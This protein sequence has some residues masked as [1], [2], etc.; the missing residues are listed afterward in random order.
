MLKLILFDYD[1]LM[2]NSEQVVYKAL[3]D[4]FGKYHHDLT[5]EYYTRHI[6]TPVQDALT[7]FFADYPLPISYDEFFALRNTMVAEYLA[8][9]LHLMPGLLSLLEFLS[10][11]AIPLAITT[12]G[13]RDYIQKGLERFRIGQ[14]FQTIVC[15]DDVKRGK[16]YPDLILE[17]LHRASCKASDAILL[18]DSP[19]GIE[20][21]QRAQIASIAIPTTGVD[22]NK[23][24]DASAIC[25]NLSEVEHW[26][27]LLSKDI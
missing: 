25:K 12:S 27:R 24:M 22:Y 9:E 3:K 7:H 4:L 8:T 6:G 1:G 19:S 23:F 26:F 13:K 10:S 11:Q 21:A 14:Y 5:W 17:T 2:V 15:I 18:E 16:P 20:A